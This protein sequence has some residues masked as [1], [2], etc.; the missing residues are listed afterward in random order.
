[1]IR[2][3][4]IILIG[5]GYAVC[6]IIFSAY[7]LKKTTLEDRKNITSVYLLWLVAVGIITTQLYF[8]IDVFLNL[9]K[10]TGEFKGLFFFI[11]FVFMAFYAFLYI[12][13]KM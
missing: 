4:P 11:G 3:I 10:A 13:R 7:P 1:M 12:K 6:K 5:G 8:I 9:F 2:I